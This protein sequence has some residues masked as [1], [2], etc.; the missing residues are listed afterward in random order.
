MAASST[1]R[2]SRAGATA[3]QVCGVTAANHLP[4]SE[5]AS[6]TVTGGAA[7]V[8]GGEV[9][10]VDGVGAS[11]VATAATGGRAVTGGWAATAGWAVVTGDPVAG[12]VVVGA[13]TVAEP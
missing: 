12:V 3:S 8:V 13:T 6:A 10:E 1:P 11:V 4:R 2:G 5:T 7:A 9:A